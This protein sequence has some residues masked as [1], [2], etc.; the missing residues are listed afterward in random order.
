M[1]I[2]CWSGLLRLVGWLLFEDVLRVAYWFGQGEQLLSKSLIGTR[3]SWGGIGGVRSLS[4]HMLHIY[5]KGIVPGSLY[6]SNLGLI[7]PWVD[8]MR[9]LNKTTAPVFAAKEQRLC[10]HLLATI[11]N[12]C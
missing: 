10:P 7:G 6:D 9:C 4:S 2:D 11:L 3:R 1:K 5:L 12:P 8:K